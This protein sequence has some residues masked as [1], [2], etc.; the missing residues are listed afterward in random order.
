MQV[1]RYLRNT[2]VVTFRFIKMKLN[3][4]SFFYQ[5][6]RYFY[7]FIRYVQIDASF[8]FNGYH[9]GAHLS[10]TGVDLVYRVIRI[11][12]LVRFNSIL[13]GFIRS[14]MCLLEY[15]WNITGIHW[16]SLGIIKFHWGILYSVFILV[17]LKFKLFGY[18]WVS[19]SINGIHLLQNI[20]MAVHCSIIRVQFG[21]IGVSLEFSELFGYMYLPLGLIVVLM[22]SITYITSPL[23][24]SGASL[25][26]IWVPLVKRRIDKY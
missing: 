9:V 6:I 25:G 26:Y 24:L 22:V 3:G 1:I 4:C 21:F 16:G 10:N 5:F 23:G 17:L 2:F 7:W 14:C 8:E 20:F 19:L 18:Y 13:M 12:L 15:H 11:P